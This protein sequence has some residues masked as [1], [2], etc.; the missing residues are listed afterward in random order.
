[1]A[2]ETDLSR[3]R[4][5]AR[6]ALVELDDVSQ[7]QVACG[8]DNLRSTL[9]AIGQRKSGQA[10]RLLAWLQQHDGHMP[11]SQGQQ[12]TAPR[13]PGEAAAAAEPGPSASGSESPDSVT[14]TPHAAA[15]ADAAL[16]I[17]RRDVTPDL[18]VFRVARPGDFEFSPGQSVKLGLGDIRRS[19]SIVSAPHEA[20]LEFFVELAPGGQMSEQLRRLQVGDTLTLGPP[21]GG[22]RFDG[23]MPNHL[24]IATVTGINP[25][26]SI[27]RD[28]LHRGQRAHRMVLMQGASYQDEFGYRQELEA[29]AAAHPDLLTYLP[30]VSR[31]DEARNQGWTGVTGRV[32][33]LV[34]EVLTHH[35]LEPRDTL[36]YACGHSGMLESVAG[37]LHPR[38]FR[39][40]TESYD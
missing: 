40:E 37:H 24:M 25:F 30:T 34:E 35:G 23:R 18:I 33:T 13:Q 22:L 31:P 39:L 26:I 16:V 7:R 6:Q 28:C 1:M 2:T 4:Q 20:F 3:G 38:G 21:K 12:P 19:Y 32:D 11:A 17:E 8:D 10:W 27:L 29:L 5:V 9:Q 14:D 15:T 36:A